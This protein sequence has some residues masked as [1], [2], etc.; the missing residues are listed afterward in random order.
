MS[1][2]VKTVLTVVSL[3]IAVLSTCAAIF[4]YRTIYEEPVIILP[5]TSVD[6]RIEALEHGY[7]LSG[8]QLDILENGSYEEITELI[9]ELF[10]L[11]GIKRA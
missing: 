5:S 4:L 2:K 3:I 7:V 11:W 1:E 8:E 6:M 10:G 9:N